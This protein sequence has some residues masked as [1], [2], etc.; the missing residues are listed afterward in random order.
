MFV[1]VLNH[2][3]GVLVDLRVE[4]ECLLDGVVLLPELLV[5]LLHLLSVVYE[6]VLD[7]GVPAV[8]GLPRGY[9]R[10]ERELLAL[11]QLLEL[12]GRLGRL[13]LLGLLLEALQIQA[14]SRVVLLPV[15]LVRPVIELLPAT[16]PSHRPHQPVSFLQGGHFRVVLKD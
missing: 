13:N 3:I 1:L 8:V 4:I 14:D 10:L 9:L 5:L 2:E 6:V 11:F 12:L 15:L 16:R 7:V